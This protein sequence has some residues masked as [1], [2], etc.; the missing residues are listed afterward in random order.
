ANLGQT[1]PAYVDWD[2]DGIPDLVVL[3]GRLL[4]F[5]R[6]VGTAAA[7]K[8]L[9]PN[10]IRAEDGARVISHRAKPALVDWDGDGLV[11]VIGHGEDLQRLMLFRRYRDTAAGELKLRPGEPLR[12]ADGSLIVPTEWHRYTKFYN[13]GDWKGTGAYDIFLGVSDQILHLE[14]VGTNEAPA[15]LPPVRLAVDGEPIRV[16]HHE[17]L[18]VPVD[19]DGTGRPDLFVS[20][21]SGLF[22]LFRRAYLDGDH[23]RIRCEIAEYEGQAK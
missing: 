9:G 14:N 1:S 20:G 4:L 10:E 2:G 5:L 12:Y 13:V 22:H 17:S 3:I 11:D 8:L 18:P 6:N 23:R 7:P 15:F 21:E 16:G 19:W